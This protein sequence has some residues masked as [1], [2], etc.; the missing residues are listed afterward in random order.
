MT[1]SEKTESMSSF[2]EDKA[3]LIRHE[4]KRGNNLYFHLKECLKYFFAH[5]KSDTF[6]NFE[7]I[8]RKMKIEKNYAIH[9]ESLPSNPAVLSTAKIQQKLFTKSEGDEEEPVIEENAEHPFPNVMESAYQLE[10]AG[11]GLGLCETVNLTL[12][13]KQLVSSIPVKSARFWGKIFGIMQNIYVVEV[14]FEE[15]EDMEEDVE[16][17]ESPED[18]NDDEGVNDMDDEDAD[19]ARDVLPKNKWK[20]PQ[21]VPKEPNN[22]LGVN[23]KAYY[24]CHEPGLKWMRLPSVTPQQIVAART[25]RSLFTGNLDGTIK[26]S[27]AYPG[28]EAHYLRAQIAR[29]SSSTHISPEGYFQLGRGDEEEEEQLEDEEGIPSQECTKNP[30]YEPVGPTELLTGGLEN[31]VH[32]RS[33]ILPQGRVTWWNPS[34]NSNDEMEDSLEEVDEEEGG[35]ITKPTPPRPERGPPI[36]TKISSDMPIFGYPA[37]SVRLSSNLMP[38]HASVVVSSILW[39]GAHA[40][41]WGKYFENVYIGWGIKE[42]GPGFQPHLPADPLDEYTDTVEITE[43]S[44]PTPEEEAAVRAAHGTENSPEEDGE[45]GDEDGSEIYRGDEEPEED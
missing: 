37:W 31:W 30:E 23:Q 24:V 28:T 17:E 42:S 7:K 29:I 3:L 27:P 26:C 34:K 35:E 9:G 41:A 14:E 10:L 13:I 18:A 21:K 44:D 40:V 33:Y 45:H 38:E 11:I 22:Q 19:N 5:T 15:G 6:T 16:D 39:P 32:H 4:D 8:S 36:L 12:A 2:I 43:I 25:T 1:L 20:P